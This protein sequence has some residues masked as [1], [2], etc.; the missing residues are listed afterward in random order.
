MLVP[1]VGKTLLLPKS[2]PSG[3]AIRNYVFG[4]NETHMTL[5]LDYGSL[6]N[7]HENRNMKA[8]EVQFQVRTRFEYFPRN[9]VKICGI[10]A[11]IHVHMHNRDKST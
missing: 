5:V 6:L 1:I 2:F 8:A 9:A 10:H 3:Q 4:H 11:C 7:H